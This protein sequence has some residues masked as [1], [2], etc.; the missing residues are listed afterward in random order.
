M[1]KLN[2]KITAA[3]ASSHELM[4][5][6]VSSTPQLCVTKTS[7]RKFWEKVRLLSL[8]FLFLESSLVRRCQ[9]HTS[10]VTVYFH[11]QVKD[12]QSDGGK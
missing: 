1:F 2:V 10:H 3:P 7:H 4:Y 11:R 8:F 9:R 6:E 5:R 12:L